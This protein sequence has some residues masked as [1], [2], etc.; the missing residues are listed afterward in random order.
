MNKQFEEWYFKWKL[1]QMDSEDE[2][3]DKQFYIDCFKQY[4][5]ALQWGVYL[6]FFD[7]EGIIIDIRSGKPF[8]EPTFYDAIICNGYIKGGFDTRPEAQQE[9][10][11]KAFEIL[12]NKK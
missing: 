11:K 7:S 9:A 12:E 2:N 6:E 8:D 10:I 5:I 3:L 1:K 4:P